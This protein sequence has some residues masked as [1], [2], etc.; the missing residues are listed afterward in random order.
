MD[1]KERH[2]VGDVGLKLWF[3]Y[4]YSCFSLHQTIMA[5]SMG[6]VPTRNRLEVQI[7]HRAFIYLWLE[8]NI[9]FYFSFYLIKYK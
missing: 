1:P 7:F 5:V 6:G 8:V 4:A 9:V 3:S 2:Q